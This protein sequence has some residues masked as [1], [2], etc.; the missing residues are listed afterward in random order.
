MR[1][2]CHKESHYVL[3]LNV[4]CGWG[5]AINVNK[6]NYK[7]YKYILYILYINKNDTQKFVS[8]Y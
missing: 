5:G 3:C 1:T 6:Y 2:Y 7:Q 4:G 8:S